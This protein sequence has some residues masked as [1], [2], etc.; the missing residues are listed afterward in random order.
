MPLPWYSSRPLQ[1][2]RQ[3]VADLLILG[4]IWLCFD[5]G[6][7][8]QARFEAAVASTHQLRD[9]ANQVT[10]NINGAANSVASAPLVG[11]KVA[12]PLR[13]L[14]GVTTQ[15]ANLANQLGT[16]ITDLGGSVRWVI[17]LAPTIPVVLVWLLIRL[18]FTRHA[19]LTQRVALLANGQELLALRALLNAS[20]TSLFRV[21]ADPAAAWRS[22]DPAAVRL[23]AELELK[24]SGASWPRPLPRPTPKPA[25]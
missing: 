16:Q 21:S 23:L 10:G 1:A 3:L 20:P 7:R 25:S 8:V 17:W 22:G 6:N 4:W 15:L 2:L 14:T 12:A 5:F 19:Y 11:G 13:S 24:R 18:R 9:G